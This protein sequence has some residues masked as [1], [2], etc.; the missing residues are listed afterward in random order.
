[1]ILAATACSSAHAQDNAPYRTDTQTFGTP[2]ISVS[3][4][5][6]Y[7]A[8]DLVEAAA[9]RLASLGVPVTLTALA[10]TIEVIYRED[11][12]LLAEVA[13]LQDS[14]GRQFIAVHEGTIDAILFD[15]FNPDLARSLARILDPVT[16]ERPVR[17]DTFERSLALASDLAGV[18]V[19]GHVVP[20]GD[21]TVL[22]VD[23]TV[24]R[25]SGIAGIELIPSRPGHA[26][27][28]FVSQELYSLGVPGDLL[29][30]TGLVS[31]EQR[32]SLSAAAFG[33]YRAPVSATGTYV[34]FYGGNVLGRR[35]FN[36]NQ[37]TFRLRGFTAGGLIGF[38]T[39]R[40]LQRFSYIIAEAEYQ[41]TKSRIGRTQAES[42]ALSARLHWTHGY[43]Y[44]R[45]GILR[46]GLTA[47]TGVR[48][49]SDLPSFTDGPRHFAHLRAEFGMVRIVSEDSNSTIRI[50]GRAQITG[51][52]LP[53]VERFA[54]G[55]SPFLRG[56][57]PAEIDGDSGISATIEFSRTFETISAGRFEAISPFVFLSGGAT[58]IERPR[59]VFGERKSREAASVGVGADIHFGAWQLSGWVAMPLIDGPRTPAGDPAAFLSLARGW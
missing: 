49:D 5:A 20:D 14:S 8:A 57:A 9:Q 51:T 29:R 22:S 44:V 26:V 23:G 52:T 48:P 19:Q 32:D 41:R 35:T 10:E 6:S 39:H 34:E 2:A 27:R 16:R 30:V 11:G 12:Y 38:T 45:G 42:E 28:G 1:M 55:H 17:Q 47:S 15:G 3:G 24:R 58:A 21:R 33:M 46:W 18:R 50:D 7:D 13:V 37:D 54:M 4:I 25:Q 31:G 53:E 40:D 43:D 56:Y 36:D 59:A